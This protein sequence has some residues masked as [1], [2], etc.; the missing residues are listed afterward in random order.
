MTKASA[1]TSENDMPSAP[2]P[3]PSRSATVPTGTQSESD[4]LDVRAEVWR[5]RPLLRAIYNRYFAEMIANFARADKAGAPGE[6]GFGT[7]LEI[8]GGSGNFKQFF[9]REYARQG[10]LIATDVVPTP[11]CDLAADAMALPF[12]DRSIDNIVMQD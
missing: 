9:L 7:I 1:F 2:L 12:L 5:R 6:G 8:G 10:D 11:H 4:V 3:H